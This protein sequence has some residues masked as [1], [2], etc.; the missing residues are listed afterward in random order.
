MRR[1]A[2]VAA[3]AAI[4]IAGGTTVAEDATQERRPVFPAKVELVD[5]ELIVVDEDG[6]PVQDL[7]PEEFRLE[8]QGKP[9]RV[10]TAEF[11]SVTEEAVETPAEEPGFAT[12]E[13]V[14]PGRLVLLVVDTA[15]IAI[16]RGRDVM[17]AA[18][19]ML[20][21]LAPTDRVGLVTIPWSGPREEFTTD[22]ERI[23]AA[24]KK[25]IG[26]GR[27]SGKNIS[28]V[29]AFSGGA[30]MIARECWGVAPGQLAGC[31]QMVRA[32]AWGLALEYRESQA[33]SRSLLEA[34]FEALRPIEG[35]KVVILVSQGLGFPDLGPRGGGGGYELR[36][37]VR[38]AS[39]A[40]VAFYIVPVRTG[41][42]FPDIDSDIPAQAVAEARRFHFSGL[43]AL[44]AEAGATVL[45]G[46][47]ER[48]FGRIVRETTGYYRLGFEPEGDDRSG[49]SRKLRV[50]VTRPDLAVRSRPS[51]V[52]QPRMN[53][54]EARDALVATLGSPTLATEIP[55]RVASWTLAGSEPGKVKLLIGAEIGGQLETQGLMVGYVLLNEQGKVAASARQPLIGEHRSEGSPLP[56]S[57]TVAVPPG[58]YTLRFA[59]RD[60]R[61]KLG[62]ADHQ[63]KA[64]LIAAGPLTLSDLLLGPV[65]APGRAFRPAVVPEVGADAL[66]YG[67]IYAGEDGLLDSV[68]AVF[69]VGSDGT[70]EVLHT[71][72]VRMVPTSTPGRGIVQMPL[73]LEDL[74]PGRYRARLIVSVAGEPQGV[75]TRPFRVL[76]R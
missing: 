1:L 30:D 62:S 35:H 17:E 19:G 26:R 63:L 16:G 45:R 49:K 10:V 6:D 74:D 70:S 69:E 68:S 25:V 55:V 54:R 43:E 46:V 66:V 61:G 72:A 18:A 39:A 8:V 2:V 73:L 21:R 64:G 13:T 56:Y 29:E 9:R 37:L 65:P 60:G 5:V 57:A 12:N 22:H 76:P 3:L 52:F 59:V 27:L 53:E 47:P 7:V 58:S 23:R 14:R 33:R 48:V 71:S 34:T 40:R 32:E 11:V 20:E 44:A 51:A 36:Q 15:N 41:A 31:K 67:E 24:L 38:A 42:D 4:A 50:S 75:I 28:L